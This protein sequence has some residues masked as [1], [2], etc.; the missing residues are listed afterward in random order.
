MRSVRQWERKIE[1]NLNKHESHQITFVNPNAVK[2]FKI[3]PLT[4][5]GGGVT[6]PLLS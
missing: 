6:Q 2:L 4:G 3:V 1:W 5:E